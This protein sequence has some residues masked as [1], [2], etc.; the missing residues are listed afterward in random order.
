MKYRCFFL[1]LVVLA[2]A[3][4]LIFASDEPFVDVGLFYG[5]NIQS[6]VTITSETG[7]EFGDLTD[8]RFFRTLDL[9]HFKELTLYKAGYYVYNAQGIATLDENPMVF[10]QVKGAYA[11]T[12]GNTYSDYDSAYEHFI[13]LKAKDE[14]FYLHIEDGVQILYGHYHSNAE[15]DAALVAMRS[16]YSAETIGHFVPKATRMVVYHKEQ[17]LFSFDTAYKEVG[18]KA[19]VF[20]YGGVQYRGIFFLKRLSTSDFSLINRVTLSEYLYGVVPREVMASWPE[21][22]LKAQAVAARNYVL[23]NKGKFKSFGFDVCATVNSQVY[24]GFSAEHERT[25]RAVDATANRILDYNGQMVQ[26]F[27][28]ANSGGATE[29]A[30]NV[31][32]N[33]LPYIVP[34]SDAFSL[35]APGTS[36][37]VTL[38]KQEIENTLKNAGYDI[39]A[40]KSIKIT[41]RTLSGR[42]SQII[43]EGTSGEAKLNRT[44]PRQIFGSTLF[45]SMMFG[46]E[47]GSASTEKT[48]RHGIP[49]MLVSS[50]GAFMRRVSLH[51]VYMETDQKAEFD[52]RNQAPFNPRVK[53]VDET[54]LVE[55][56]SVTF[57][58]LGFGH[59]IGMSQ[60]GAKQMADLGYDYEA[61]LK[62]YFP[63]TSIKSYVHQANIK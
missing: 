28:H 34:V 44:A 51:T 62:H 18:F 3:Q 15:A 23:M 43:F 20:A 8:G 6:A 11:L 41:E 50:R 39:G 37:S 26:A 27:Y 63:G 56:A 4:G 58:G 38:S 22:A 29:Y 12:F 48:V 9:T 61:I 53:A 30:S 35:S 31:W 25:N 33:D 49:T 2:M 60:W 1:C 42:V 21:E 16:S 36:W 7:F 40:L 52:L 13:A 57:T 45:R 14:A 5:N 59:G 32:L 54:L 10:S 47:Q 24:G 46:F 55:G 17:P 19:R